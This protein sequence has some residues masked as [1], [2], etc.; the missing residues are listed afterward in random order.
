MSDTEDQAAPDAG[1]R[2][3]T[4]AEGRATPDAVGWVALNAVGRAMPETGDR[5]APGTEGAAELLACPGRAATAYA[6]E[7]AAL[8]DDTGTRSTR[9]ARPSPRPPYGLWPGGTTPAACPA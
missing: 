4:D 8:L 6:D 1:E 7:V 5:M 3:A 9:C 2:A